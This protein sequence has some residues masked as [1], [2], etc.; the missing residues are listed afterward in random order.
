MTTKRTFT[1]DQLQNKKRLNRSSVERRTGKVSKITKLAKRNF[2][3]SP[4]VT[5]R[6][7][8]SILNEELMQTI[9]DLYVSHGKPLKEIYAMLSLG[10]TTI[11]QWTTNNYLGFRDFIREIKDEAIVEQA[12]DNMPAL[13]KSKKDHIRSINTQFVLETKGGW[14]KKS[15]VNLSGKGS[16]SQ[17]EVE[18]LLIGLKGKCGDEEIRDVEGF[19]IG[20]EEEKV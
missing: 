12:R 15:D 20:P 6:G 8:E 3:K 2:L 11:Y 19:A 18:L 16:A 5:S 13:L 9:R 1:E 10:R 7:S 17:E 14:S 4:K